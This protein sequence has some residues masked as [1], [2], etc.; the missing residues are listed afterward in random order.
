[1]T[2]T[3]TP[4][5]S[6]GSQGSIGNAITSQKYGPVTLIR[7]K[8]KPAYRY[9]LAQAY[10]RWLYEDYVYLWH[11]Q[12]QAV[13][14]T[15]RTAGVRFHLTAF[16]YWMK[17]HLTNLPDIL[18]WWKLD[19]NTGPTTIDSSRNLNPAT[20]IGAS[21]A[22][23][24][25]DRA[26]SF[27]GNNDL[28]NCSAAASL[29]P[30]LLSPRTIEFFFIPAELGRDQY[31]FGYGQPVL[32]NGTTFQVML[33]NTNIIMSIITGLGD[34]LG[35]TPIL[36]SQTYH[37][38]LTYDGTTMRLYLNGNLEGSNVI[39]LST[40]NTVCYFAMSRDADMARL[41]NGIADNGIVY[42]RVL[43][44]TTIICHSLR[45]FPP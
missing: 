11:Q 15:Y 6:L 20:I 3:K 40:A 39:A 18:A 16:Q 23:G 32:V 38:A 8:P 13:K 35:T 1:M 36:L 28:V 24:V 42:N 37:V 29:F 19:D 44:R 45:R 9:T 25:I 43:D 17:Y 10:Q 12:T 14:D 2:K 34:I 31:L 41:L 26:L 5:F 22:T 30:T 21:P 4:F 7:T 33:H 27:D